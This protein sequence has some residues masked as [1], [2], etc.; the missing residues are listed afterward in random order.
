MTSITQKRTPRA[1]AALVAGALIGGCANSPTHSTLRSIP[2]GDGIRVVGGESEIEVPN[3]KSAGETVAGGAAG[4]AAAG[5]GYGAGAGFMMGFAC[6]P[7]FVV[8]SP[9]GVVGGVA[10]GAIFGAAVGGV[11][12]AMT[13]L[14]KEKAEALETVMAATI[15]DLGGPRTLVEQF[16]VQSGD[17]WT[18]TDA[19]VATEIT[20][21]I[22]GLSIDQG[23]D[24]ALTVK[25]VNWMVVSYGPG[26]LDT[27]ERVLFTYVSG[28]HHIDHW[29][30][31]DGAN[32]QA[33]VK[34]AFAENIADMIKELEGVSAP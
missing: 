12:S 7:L 5:A 8:C 23:K 33:V 17:R 21:G 20:L 3:A 26:E 6:G 19:G 2:H 34:E 27:T 1:L 9:I 30:E 29:I 4:G 25:L 28:K 32:F 10:G 13:A 15:V 24:D 31:H 16:E 22:E 14:P 18:V 11:G